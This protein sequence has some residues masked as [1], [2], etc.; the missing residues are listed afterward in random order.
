MRE[1]QTDREEERQQRG[2]KTQRINID[3]KNEMQK[4]QKKTFGRQRED[5]FDFPSIKNRIK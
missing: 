4:L 2:D 5:C 3:Y 1:W